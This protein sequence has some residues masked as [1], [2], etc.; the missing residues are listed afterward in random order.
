MK[1][2]QDLHTLPQFSNPVLTIGSFD[3][4]HLGHRRI[5]QQLINHAEAVKGESILITFEP[6][7]RLIINPNDS[8]LKLLNT[9]Q[10]KI[11]LLSELGL[12]HLVVV[13]FD[14]QFR[15]LTAKQ[16]VSDF[17]V[18][19]FK[20]K[21][22]IIGY[23]HHFGNNREGNLNLL[24][25]LQSNFNYELV[26][27]PP[28]EIDDLAVSS[29]KI[30]NYLS[31]GNVVLA[32][33]MLMKPYSITGTVV[34]GDA[35]G[36]TI[37]YPTA[38]L[39]LHHKFKLIPGNGVYAIRAL[40]QGKHYGGMM[41]IGTRP[42]IEST[43]KISLEAHLFDFDKQIYDEYITVHLIAKLRDELKFNGIDQLISAIKKDEID[44]KKALS[45]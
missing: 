26:E 16:Y 20:P 4:V 11:N 19:K 27:I 14:E 33:Q 9:L 43:E 10:E 28:Q 5:I 36:R 24:Q 15:A 42:T 7:P 1:V 13:P 3:G 37:G 21:T 29:T 39:A 34:H 18:A 45:I 44:A 12:D 17:L 41:N 6:H 30:R 2:H 35:R 23:D 22:L 40:F 38:N 8:K 31:D 32:N 25:D